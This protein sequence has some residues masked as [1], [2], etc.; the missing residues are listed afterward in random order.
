MIDHSLGKDITNMQL[1]ILIC[2]LLKTLILWQ[3]LCFLFLF[4]VCYEGF[5][6]SKIG[7]ICWFPIM[8]IKVT[9][10]FLKKAILCYLRSEQRLKPM[11]F[12]NFIQCT[13]Q[14][15]IRTQASLLSAHK[16]KFK[17]WKEWQ[18]NIHT[19]ST[20]ILF[21]GLTEIFK[22]HI[23]ETIRRPASC[24][25]RLKPLLGFQEGSRQY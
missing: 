17:L 9:F 7:A 2:R 16:N 11:N 1:E 13:Q 24:L 8:T 22:L 10:I 12:S 15:S 19:C 3:L 20:V 25:N 18:D 4:F 14:N 6:C 5:L 23:K 21:K